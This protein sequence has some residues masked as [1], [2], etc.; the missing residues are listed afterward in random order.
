[1]TSLEDGAEQHLNTK[2]LAQ[3]EYTSAFFN[4]DSIKLEVLDPEDGNSISVVG[5]I[6]GEVPPQKNDTGLQTLCGTTDTR[7]ATF[8]NWDPRSARYMGAG[9]CTAWLINDRR[10]CFLT[11]GHCTGT[12]TVQ[13]RVPESDSNGR[14]I[15]PAPRYQYAVDSNSIQSN[16]GGTGNDWKYMGAFAN[17]ET[18]LT[19]IQDQRSSY[20]LA[21]RPQTPSQLRIFGY[22]TGT[23]RANQAQ[24][25]ARGGNVNLAGNRLTYRVDTTGGDSGSGVEDTS[26]TAYAIHTHGGCTSTGGSNSG[27]FLFLGALQTALNNPRGICA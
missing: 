3:W 5:L 9:G 16:N 11:A 12:G 2:T 6:Y 1:L 7:R 19:P 25:E 18:G 17:T 20:V 27:T 26:G 13:F 14:L 10:G 21:A 24:K 4:G 8:P 15:H 23:A 22:G